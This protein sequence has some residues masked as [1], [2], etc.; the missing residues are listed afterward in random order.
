MKNLIMIGLL[1]FVYITNIHGVTIK[2]VVLDDR[3]SAPLIGATI[4][5]KHTSINTYT[6]IDGSFHLN[7]L[8]L[9]ATLV[10]SYVG[11]ATKEVKV[12]DTSKIIIILDEEES[13]LEEVV[14][15]GLSVKKEKRSTFYSSSTIKSDD[16][17]SLDFNTKGIYTTPVN[18]INVYNAGTLTAGE[19]NDFSKWKLWNDKSQDEL[20]EYNKNWKIFPSLRYTALIQ[21]QDG[22]AISGIEVKLIDSKQNIVWK[23]QTDNLGKAELWVNMFN[24]NYSDKDKFTIEAIWN[25]KKYEILDAKSFN[26]GINHLTIKKECNAAKS[27]EVLFLVDATGS[28][29]DEINYLK[30]ELSNVMQQIKDS[31]KDLTIKLGS[32]FYRDLKD[33]YVTRISELSDDI[34]KTTN[35]ITDQHANGGDDFP[36]AVD[37]GLEVALHDIKW[38]D[39]AITK[40]IF[41][42]L[43]APPHDK[44]STLESLQNLITEAASRG[45]KIVPITASGIDKSTEYLMRAWALATN[46][47]YVFLTDDSGVGDHHI[48]PT[49]DKYDVE[50]LNDLLVRLFNQFSHTEKCQSVSIKYNPIDTVKIAG[51]VLSKSDSL[52]SADSLNK[53]E[54]D[55]HIILSIYPIPTTGIINVKIDGHLNELFLCD[56]SGKILERY[57]VNGQNLLQFNISQYPKGIYFLAYFQSEEKLISGKIVLIH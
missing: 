33:E 26:E 34:S 10:F 21:N 13:R 53:Q 43:D 47:T 11:Y 2:G 57:M 38:S 18:N 30:A 6:L 23:A 40:I 28:M 50:K 3:D 22:N 7:V 25:D 9:P 39:E 27:A 14:V 44:I 20:R 46:G 42:V 35:F 32:V 37:K 56:I 48:A 16:I 52:P 49:T 8:K 19:I 45:I 15:A 5:I 4:T 36:E 31:N 1:T 54:K 51:S 12:T 29:S 17:K 55:L 41:L 24:N